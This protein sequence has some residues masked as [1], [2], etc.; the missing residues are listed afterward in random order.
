MASCI[1]L[2][3]SEYV[4]VCASRTRQ[5]CDV[6][7]DRLQIITTIEEERKKKKG[8][9]PSMSIMELIWVLLWF[10]RSLNGRWIYLLFGV[11][12]NQLFTWNQF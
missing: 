7:A 5:I 6:V 3:V 1:I 11:G 12:G 8:S 9:K 10:G 2:H 4:S